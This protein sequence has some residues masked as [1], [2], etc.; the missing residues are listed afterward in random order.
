VTVTNGSASSEPVSA[1][2][3][4]L[5][6]A[7]FQWGS[8]AVATRTDYSPAVKNGTILGQNTVPAKPGDTIILWGTG[9]GPTNPATLTGVVVPS[10]VTYNTASPVTV[11]IGGVGATALGAA[12]TPGDV[13][14]Y[15]IAIQVPTGLANGD[16]PI[17]ATISGAQSP[18]SVLITIQQ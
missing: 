3:Q 15:Q 4:A 9:F 13:G 11:A 1:I 17:V 7:F 12:L 18:S 6:P 16:Y 5:Q 2:V 14:L 8:Y 10:G